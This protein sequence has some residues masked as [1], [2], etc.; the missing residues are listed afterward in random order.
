MNK[1]DS[2]GTY[3]GT[4]VEAALGETKNGFPQAIL[5]LAAKRKFI[6]DP[7]GMKHFGLTDPAYV[8]WSEF[9]EEAM[10]YLVLF[11]STEKFDSVTKL[12]NYDQLVIAV[13]WNGTDFDNFEEFVGKDILFRIKE[14]DYNG[15]VTLQ[16]A[17]IDKVDADPAGSLRPLDA[18]K[19]KGL[20]AKLKF[21]MGGSTAAKPQRAMGKPVSSTNSIP[22]PVL[23]VAD[24]SA[25]PASVPPAAKRGR[26]PKADNKLTKMEAWTAIEAATDGKDLGTKVPEAWLAACEKVGGEKA[27]DDFTEE[28]WFAVKTE[29]VTALGL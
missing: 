19:V 4:I 22:A 20:S 6:D 18:E 12:L 27:E 15:K 13:G 16:V 14:N 24:S 28:D 5:K 8:D 26:K 11:K 10:A 3:T 1:I 17:W 29:V 7:A 9:T 25:A 2:I 23:P 21:G